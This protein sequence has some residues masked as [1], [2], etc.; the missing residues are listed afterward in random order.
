MCSFDCVCYLVPPRGMDE[1]ESPFLSVAHVGL[2][3]RGETFGLSGLMGINR[4][5]GRAKGDGDITS[6][7]QSVYRGDVVALLI[8]VFK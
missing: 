8:S 5:G 6:S 4:S 1:L 2:V 7:G 3:K